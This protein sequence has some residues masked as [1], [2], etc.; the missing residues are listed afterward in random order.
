MFLT[1]RSVE[2]EWMDLGYYTPE[3]Y[4]D[5]LYKLDKIGRFLGGDKATFWAIDQLREPPQSIVDVGCGA[6][7][8]SMRLAKRYST[9]QVLGIDIAPEAIE[10]AQKHLDRYG[11]P[12][13]RF[14]LLNSPKLAFPANSA[15]AFISTLMCHHLRDED[16]IQFI[17]D[18]YKAARKAV[19]LNDLHRNLFAKVGYA[20]VT[21][22]LLPS[23]MVIHDGF[24][25]IRR[26]FTYQEW[27]RLLNAAE[28]PRSRYSITWH[29][30]FRWI[31]LINK[32]SYV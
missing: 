5:C 8:F 19:I 32:D 9:S 26:G 11:A 2:K 6:G 30:A 10:F 27:E 22:L 7:L 25:S 15:D 31:I 21:P 4:E 13:L 18:A 17:K 24:A 3:E 23:R 28:I 16:L 20:C 29:W 1:E 14:E 12:N